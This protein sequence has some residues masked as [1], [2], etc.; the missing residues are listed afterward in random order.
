M[1][2]INLS[3][4]AP[5]TYYAAH[6]DTTHKPAAR[7]E[8]IA[9][10]TDDYSR[11]DDYEKLDL[12]YFLSPDEFP[13][14]ALLHSLVEDYS[15]SIIGIN[16]SPPGN[17]VLPIFPGDNSGYGIR[18][19]Y[20]FI[21][22]PPFSLFCSFLSIDFNKFIETFVDLILLPYSKYTVNDQSAIRTKIGQYNPVAILF[23][24]DDKAEEF[25]DISN[26]VEFREAFPTLSSYNKLSDEQLEEQSD[27]LRD[28]LHK[29]RS[30]LIPRYVM[31]W[32]DYILLQRY[33]LSYA[34][35]PKIY[36][37]SGRFAAFRQ[38]YRIFDDEPYIT[39]MTADATTERQYLYQTYIKQDWNKFDAALKQYVNR[40]SSL[41]CR[42]I[43]AT[44]PCALLADMLE[45]IIDNHYAIKKCK[46]CGQYFVPIESKNIDYCLRIFKDKKN[47]RD[48]G[49]SIKAQEKIKKDAVRTELKRIYNRLRGRKERHPERP[50]YAQQFEQFNQEKKTLERAYKTGKLSDSE[51]LS[52]L[53]KWKK[54]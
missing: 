2:D 46:L 21:L 51:V 30:K 14:S 50:E 10:L 16:V 37:A 34:K 4:G 1:E 35:R 11:N 17:A 45:M 39:K 42:T 3:K 38:R 25:K 33:A 19:K 18:L 8:C 40:V 20:P 28:E 53:A 44:H 29:L 5:R 12:Y 6:I 7:G 47:C 22:Q 49:P 9:L 48:I 26:A 13:E 15:L 32:F 23:D 24:L 43:V 27:K 31:H 36:G 54:G 41:R 52:A